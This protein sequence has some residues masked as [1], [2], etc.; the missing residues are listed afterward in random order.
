MLI[1][2][3]VLLA[4][5]L[6]GIGRLARGLALVPES[7]TQLGRRDGSRDEWREHR[8]LLSAAAVFAA[9]VLISRNFVLGVIAGAAV[10]LWPLIVG[11]GKA[12]RAALAKLDAL[13]Q[14]T[15]ALRDL[16]QKGAGLESV[17]PKTIPTASEVLAPSLRHLSFRLSV[18]VPLPEALSLFAD[19][20]DDAGADLVVAALA[21]SARQRKGQLSRVLSALSSALRDELEARTRIMRERNVVRREAAQVAGLSAVL[22][23]GATLFAPPTLP[24]SASTAAEVLPFLLAGAFFLVFSRV[25]KL[26]EP[27]AEPRFLSAASEV[28]EAATYRPKAVGL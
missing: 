23:F 28:L 13:A 5:G 14:W 9:V 17:I 27:E 25:R 19:E 4:I 6:I 12:E 24:G 20:V 21:L 18:R 2:L 8:A 7:L 15:E 1:G 22:V 3:G 16:A 10:V 26:A 11:G